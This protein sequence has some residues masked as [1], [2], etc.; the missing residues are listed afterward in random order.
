MSVSFEKNQDLQDAEDT[1]GFTRRDFFKFLAGSAVSLAFLDRA[2]ASV[3]QSIK[4]LN[5]KYLGDESPDGLY[6]E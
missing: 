1:A 2:T 5:Q 4:T 6:W 3:Y